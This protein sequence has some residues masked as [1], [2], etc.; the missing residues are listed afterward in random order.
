MPS[1][2]QIAETTRPPNVTGGALGRNDD[3]TR[4]ISASTKPLSS[5]QSPAALHDVVST[6]TAKKWCC[7]EHDTCLTPSTQSIVR[8]RKPSSTPPIFTPPHRP[9][10][11]SVES[12][13]EKSPR[14]VSAARM[15]R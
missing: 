2:S 4:C 8:G 11:P 3:D 7:L 6:S 14:L 1:G 5:R 10:L 13:T 9:P 12:A 15:N